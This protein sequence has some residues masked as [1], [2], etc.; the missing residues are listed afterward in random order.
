MKFKLNENRIEKI[1][2][3]VCGFCVVSVILL[4]MNLDYPFVGHD[5]RYFIPR[6]LDTDLHI[7]LNGLSVQWYTPSFG[8]GLPAY[9]N[10][11]HLEYSL[12][13]GLSFFI[14]P[15]LAILLTT[16]I[17]SFIGYYYFFK[18]LTEIL[19]VGWMSGTLG[20]MFFL[21]N[22][23]YIEHMIA[24][25]LGFQLFPLAA[26]ILYLLLEMHNKYL[27]NAIAIALMIAMILYQGGFFI[28][29]VISMS[30]GITLPMLYLYKPEIFDLKR[31]SRVVAWAIFLSA[32]I[33]GSKIYATLSFMKYFPREIFDNYNVGLSQALIGIVAQL[34]GV[35]TLMPVFLITHTYSEFLSGSLSNITGAKYGI[36]EI[37][38]GLSPVLLIIL[39]VGLATLISQICRIRTVK[40]SRS[41]VYAS[42]HIAGY[43]LGHD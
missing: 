6:L 27:Y 42:H 1:I 43:S 2:T 3:F 34:F 13:Q 29:V 40:F 25:H 16:G 21:G 18:F 17:V 9:P 36:W 19:A 33:A 41:Q 38:T 10:P 30:F 15:W 14:N 37:D 20:A 7:R 5:Y 8:G 12:V 26:V 23:F 4:L 24:G 39:L 11:Q 31:T 22:G 35:M 28:A 32:C